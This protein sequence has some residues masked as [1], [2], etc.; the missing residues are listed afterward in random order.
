MK[1][2]SRVVRYNKPKEEE[3]KT[4]IP[5]RFHLFWVPF[6]EDEA[7][8]PITITKG[9]SAN[10]IGIAPSPDAIDFRLELNQYK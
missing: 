2:M 4:E 10:I 7:W 9:K 1:Y 3:P 5:P 8:N 6:I